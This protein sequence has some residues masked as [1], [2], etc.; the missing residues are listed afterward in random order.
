MEYSPAQS[1]IAS[2]IPMALMFSAA[3]YAALGLHAWRRRPAP[4]IMPFVW[5]MLA[6]AHWSFFY[7]LEVSAD[8]LLA[9]EIW[10]KIEFLGVVSLPVS[11][12]TFALEYTG[13]KDWLTRRNRAW[14]WLV[15][16]A[17][18][19][20]V[21]TNDLHGL[22][23]PR[24]DLAT[25]AGMLLLS[26]EYGPLFWSF[27][28][29][30]Y[31][32][33]AMGSALLVLEMLRAPGIYR[34]Q[35]GTLLLGIL[36]PWLGSVAF[37]AGLSPIRNLDLT[38]FAFI[39]TGLAVAWSIARFR[40]LDVLPLEH[41]TVLE[42]LQDA[43]LV[44]DG[45]LRLLYLNPAA[46]RL[47]GTNFGRT[48]GQPLEQVCG[49]RWRALTSMFH[50]KEAHEELEI[51]QEGRRRCFD[52]RI[53]PI[54]I[55]EGQQEA[56]KLHHLAILRDVTDGRAAETALKRREAILWAVSLAA[57]HF[58]RL[59]DW[60]QSI[61]IVLEQLGQAA[62]VSRVYICE[63]HSS[64]DGTPLVSQR[65]EWVAE[66]IS[67]QIDNPNLQ[68]LPWREAGFARWE[69]T[70]LGRE[71]IFGLIR[72]FPESE[73]EL[74]SIQD[75]LSIAVMPIFINKELW[76]FIGFDECRNEREW[77]SAELGTLRAAA[78]IFGA[79]LT[80]MRAYEAARRHAQNQ[81]ALFRLST[82]LAM[83]LSEPEIC[84]RVVSGLHDNLRYDHVGL[85]LL[86]EASGDRVLQAS[87]G[88]PDAPLNWRI[89]P[90]QG[91][92]ELCLLEGQ[93]HYT[94]D[95]T[96]EPRYVP[97]VGRGC[98]V[99]VPIRIG[100]QI[101]GVL[102]AESRQPHAFNQDDFAVLSAAAN[103]A[104]LALTRASS[105]N[106]ERRQLLELSALY[107]VS[108]AVARAADE[109]DLIARV[110]EIVGKKLYPSN[111]G[112]L[113]LDE[114]AGVLR[115]HPS[116]HWTE[117]R[118]TLEIPLGVGVTGTVA[119][120]KKSR[121]IPD[122]RQATEYL[123]VEPTTIS[124]LCVPMMVGKT[125]MGVINAES[126]RADA[127]TSE[128]ERLMMTLAGHLASAIARLRAAQVESRVY[129]Q[130]ARSNALIEALL[131]VA[132]Q[133]EKAATLAEVME[134]L[135]KE[136]GKLDLACMLM[137]YQQEPPCDWAQGKPD[138]IVH[139]TSLDEKQ[140]QAFEKNLGVA[141]NGL[142][143]PR[144][145]LAQFIDFARSAPSVLPD[146]IG[147]IAASL[148]GVS[149]RR[150]ERALKS[151]GITASTPVAHLPLMFEERLLGA[152]W[153]WGERLREND[154]P[155][156]SVFANQVAAA[157]ENTR[158]FAEV[159][160]LAV[161]DELTGVS[162][163]RHF[164][165]QA[166]HEFY[167]SR[168]HGQPFAILMLDIDH[169]KRVNDRHGHLVGD[170]V[171]QELAALC[172]KHLRSE[173]I[174]GRYGGEEFVILLS[175]TDTV[176]AARV[177]ER[178]HRAIAGMAIPDG[179]GMDVSVTVSVGVAADE[180]RTHNLL[181]VIDRADQAMYVAKR[182][183]RN[184]VAVISSG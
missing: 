60:D 7:A 121:R 168:R 144:G 70:F 101:S 51:T 141:V 84:Q 161:T 54:H 79:A 106:A 90:G 39:P 49:S 169:F 143:L 61:P 154:L 85:F 94:P 71:A 175:E 93:L 156:M 86:D 91:I 4:A 172:R 87:V 137:L 6:M 46:E 138:L 26:A 124:E 30:S 152:L 176:T 67:P 98:E 180:D 170:R 40:L 149:R 146:V 15:P 162:N 164:F 165:D 96:R 163:R 129:A 88:W 119:L 115:P 58:F 184:R 179:S 183:G 5:M 11:W 116:Y 75:I 132:G 57:Q 77:S 32:L 22:I 36:A 118:P 158:L 47:M 109:D 55:S 99:D 41:T 181:E 131:H 145:V 139:Y 177:A 167:R 81:A 19:L 37:I 97:G 92:S 125:L 53:T 159:Q 157:I 178:L 31:L 62:D 100:N 147:V 13:R 95:V 21:W 56:G 155:I 10:A 108:L 64:H 18:L 43:V 80:K 135:G 114:A 107:E 23:W 120:E 44:A 66:G 150:V 9:K 102:I 123:N 126:A 122:I 73:R 25:A 12:L 52:V 160:R 182:N 35:A 117:T 89:P 72:E 8:T 174:I 59:E 113:L 82:D 45:R 140:A 171:L 38:P 142:S 112:V 111:F 134:T 127:F 166:Y 28:V 65:F 42:H 17:T 151:A 128:D 29:Y 1:Y 2:L 20:L 148:G 34:A 130:L 68:N 105:V 3:I 133:I 50:A 69:D 76:G 24:L 48:I 78:D 110:T 83:S 173:D 103:L 104:S 74:L 14:L 16:A 136:F 63:R 153:L 33:L 27:I